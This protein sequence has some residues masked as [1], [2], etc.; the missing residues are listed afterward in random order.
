MKIAISTSGK[1]LNSAYDPR[2]GRAAYFCRLDTETEGFEA[3]TN[4][5][6]SA[7][8]GAGVQASQ[9]IAA[10]G[11]DAVISG[12]FGPNAY[13]TLAAA[14]IKMYLA[15]PGNFTVHDLLG[16]Y[17]A[18]QLEQ[19]TAPSHQGHHSGRRRQGGR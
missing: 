16:R 11:A 6:I 19:A 2:F 7:A 10:Q 13:D 12:A 4:P 17:K 1:D 14:G 3:L 9:F 18:N 5:A 15:P 8:G